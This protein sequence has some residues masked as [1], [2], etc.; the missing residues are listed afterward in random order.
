MLVNRYRMCS[1]LLLFLY[2]SHLQKPAALINL[3]VSKLGSPIILNNTLNGEESLGL[4]E[5][6]K[7]S[8][9]NCLNQSLLIWIASSMNLHLSI[10]LSFLRA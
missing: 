5:R 2:C 6:I 4:F 7:L 10:I 3:S 1:Y 9:V 8:L